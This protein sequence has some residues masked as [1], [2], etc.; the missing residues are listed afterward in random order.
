MKR[1]TE[2]EEMKHKVM[3]L[4]KD[5]EGKEEFNQ[6]SFLSGV[7][8]ALNWARHNEIETI[9]VTEDIILE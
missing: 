8:T 9:K 1:V 5:S 3:E 2:I 6:Y 4:R 7:L